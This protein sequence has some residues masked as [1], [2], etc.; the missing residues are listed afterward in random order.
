MPIERVVQLHV[1]GHSRRDNGLLIDT[2]G[3]PVRD[4]VYELLELTLQ[5]TGPVPVLLE[6]DQNFPSFEQLREELERIHAI[7][8][9]A[10]GDS[11]A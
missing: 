6:R 1:A 8:Q 2:H 4:G 10:T 5:R 3:E 7:Y 9:R 11:W